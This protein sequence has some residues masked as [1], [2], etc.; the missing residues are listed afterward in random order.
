MNKIE[1]TPLANI[2]VCRLIDMERSE[3]GIILPDTQHKGVTAFALVESIGSD[4]T[5]C[6]EGDVIVPRAVEHCYLRGGT[7]HR[8]F[9]K[10]EDVHAIVKS[11]FDPKHMKFVDERLGAGAERPRIQP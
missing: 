1:L 8:V 3:A 10:N 11:G 6:K 2:M 7:F 5:R 9:V 4:V